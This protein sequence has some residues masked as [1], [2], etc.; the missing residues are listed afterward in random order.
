MGPGPANADPRILAAQSLPLLGHMCAPR[1]PRAA[2]PRSQPYQPSLLPATPSCCPQSLVRRHPPFLKIMDEV[3]QGLRYLFQTDSK[4]TLCASGTGHAGMEMAIANLLEPG[5]KIVVG[6]NGIW[7]SRA[8]G[9]AHCWVA[10]TGRHQLAPC[11]RGH[12]CHHRSRMHL[13]C[14]APMP[15]HARVRH[16]GPLWGRGGQPAD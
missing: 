8:G 12:R 7:V 3:Q 5:E 10:T 4:Y 6:N 15:G 13:V 9:R 2:T 14:A 11:I 1:R 16:G